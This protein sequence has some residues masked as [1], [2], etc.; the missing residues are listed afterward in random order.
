MGCQ[1][2]QVLSTYADQSVPYC[3]SSL[4]DCSVSQE[5]KL[6]SNRQSMLQTRWI[7]RTVSILD[8]VPGQGGAQCLLCVVCPWAEREW[9]FLGLGQRRSSNAKK[10]QSKARILPDS[11]T[12]NP[13]DSWHHVAR[14]PQMVGDSWLG[15]D[16]LRPVAW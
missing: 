16:S 10:Q 7:V 2:S 3:H 13:Q 12:W 4:Q 9:P 1:S 14:Q 6:C 8:S 15:P 11:L 5:P